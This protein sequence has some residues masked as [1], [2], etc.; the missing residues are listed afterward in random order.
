MFQCATLS[1]N[2]LTRA[3]DWG[4]SKNA[5]QITHHRAL[6]ITIKPDSILK[7]LMLV[8]KLKRAMHVLQLGKENNFRENHFHF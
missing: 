7:R 2:Y 3:T 6:G 4:Q 5:S 8:H 1:N